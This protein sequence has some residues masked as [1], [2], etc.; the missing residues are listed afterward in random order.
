MLF[1]CA[2][3]FYAGMAQKV[4][5]TADRN[6]IL[7]GEQIIMQL[8]AEDINPRTSVLQNWF[9]LSDSTDHIKIVKKEPIDT[10]EINGY[11]TYLQKITITSFDSGR[12]QITPSPIILQD[13]ATGKKTLLKTGSV[14][15]DVLPVDVSGLQDYHALKDILDVEAKPDYTLYILIAGSVIVLVIAVLLLRKMFAKKNLAPPKPVYKGTALEYAL[16]Q[17]KELQQQNLIAGNQVKLFYTKLNNIC[18]EYFSTQLTVNASQTTSDELMLT[19][20]VYLQD[21]KKRT[22]FFQLMRLTD[23]VKFAKYIPDATQH[24]EAIQTAVASLQHID[25]QIKQTKQHDN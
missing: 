16:Q 12:W 5:V 9:I 21:E 2:L 19:L 20:I 22:A 14:V 13:N 25:Q 6:K 10:I 7:L 15:V 17:I 8:K 4:S 3:L 1:T 18:R 11:T 23:A 24:E